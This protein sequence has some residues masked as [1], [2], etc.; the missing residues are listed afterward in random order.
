M[1]I[2][3]NLPP[4]TGVSTAIDSGQAVS[5]AD[6]DR[7][8]VLVAE[9]IEE[10]ASILSDPLGLPAQAHRLRNRA[11]KVRTDRF[12]VL[13]V[14]EFKRGKSTLLNAMLG[15][16]VMPRKAAECTAVVTTIQYHDQPHVKVIYADN[17]VPRDLSVDEFRQEFELKVDDAG[18]DRQAAADRF[19][20]VVRAELYYPV[21]LCRHRVELVDSPG[22]G[23][24]RTRTERVTKFVHEA[25]AVVFVLHAMQFLKDDE[26]QFLESV[27]LP[28]GLRNI[29][30]VINWYNLMEEQLPGDRERD[31]A[32][33]EAAIRLRLTPFCNVGGIDRTNERV[34]RVNA[35]AALRAR[36]GSADEAALERSRIPAF[37]RSLERFLI[38]DR[39]RARNDATLG[40]VRKTQDDVNTH[41]ANQNALASKSIAEIEAKRVALQPKL[42]KLRGIKRHIEDFLDTKSSLLRDGLAISF[43]KHL[44]RIDKGLEAAVEKFN[45]SDVLQFPI[46]LRILM[47]WFN[48]GEDKFA[49]RLE[50]ALKP[51]VTR[52]LE[53]EFAVWQSS[54]VS[55]E[56]RAVTID[57]EKHL[58]EEAAEYRRV[59]TE[60]QDRLGAQG[61]ALP[62]KEC[63]DRWLSGGDISGDSGGLQMPHVTGGILG[64]LSLII[65]SIV[66]EIMIH[67]LTNMMFAG[68]PFL[69]ILIAGVRM[70]LQ[71]KQIRRNINAEISKGI[72]QS[73]RDLESSRTALIRQEIR[74]DF[75][76]L[77]RKVTSSI[78]DEIALIDGS[79]QAILDRKREGEQRAEEERTRLDEARARLTGIADRIRPLLAS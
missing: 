70:G 59:I 28:L 29:F 57:V 33:L 58:Q 22:I 12:K 30:F 49:A 60:I 1:S 54:V 71:D 19:S 69:G 72:R 5:L 21:E 39:A 79:I 17:P 52:H 47:D 32:E 67:F 56:L 41:V 46:A 20:H 18:G 34:F 36:L 11:D 73:L 40:L 35:L 37:E 15:G 16:D 31:E 76:S 2:D 77:K 26:G 55:N 24:H 78:D 74:N 51:Q 8:A 23:A 64:D 66:A 38:E 27:L 13:V 44:E 10:M 42:D 7:N 50:K 61:D 9:A 75:D 6:A 68:I 62:I 3:A 14:G 65:G 63:V 48:R 43:Q 4:N 25:D 45:L 53:R